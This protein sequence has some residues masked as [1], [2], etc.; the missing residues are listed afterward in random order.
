MKRE[1]LKRCKTAGV[2]AS[3]GRTKCDVT[4]MLRLVRAGMQCFL[5]FFLIYI[6]YV[7]SY[8]N[9]KKV[10]TI[11]KQVSHVTRKAK[12]TYKSV[13]LIQPRRIRY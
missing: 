6:K 11:V 2:S 3:L 9:T 5:F 4:F 13:R 7:L 10:H 1:V 8:R 12:N